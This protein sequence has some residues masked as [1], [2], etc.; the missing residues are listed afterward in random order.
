VSKT[1]KY[2]IGQAADMAGG[3]VMITDRRYSARMGWDYKVQRTR[4]EPV[5]RN[6]DG[7]VMTSTG[8]PSWTQEWLVRPAQGS[9]TR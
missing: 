8:Y 2:E 1:P 5:G 4:P 9:V 6:R 7:S 3:P